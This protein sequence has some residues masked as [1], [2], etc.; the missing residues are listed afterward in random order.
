[1]VGVYHSVNWKMDGEMLKR[2]LKNEHTVS[3]HKLC[4]MLLG[5]DFVLLFLA[6]IFRVRRILGVLRT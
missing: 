2:P 5:T 1:L 3:S 4:N 6:I